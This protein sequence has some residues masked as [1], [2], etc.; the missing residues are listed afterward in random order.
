MLIQLTNRDVHTCGVL[1]ADTV[2]LCK[3]QNFNP[4]LEN[5]NQSREDANIDGFKA[6]FA[7][8]RLFNLDP[9]TLNVTS[10]HGA[11]LWLTDNACIDVKCSSTGDLI[12]DTMDK[13]GADIA[14][15]CQVT[16]DPTVV[17]IQGWVS[18][19]EFN[20]KHR[21]K[22]YGYGERLVMNRSELHPIEQLWR[23]MVT[24]KFSPVN[25]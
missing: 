23:Q 25:K 15:L 5:E 16:S 19:I 8:A 22:D 21:I 20:F 10:D 4:R 13:F 12:F 18:R 17:E 11:D 2:K 3:M 24:K 1:G 7:V 14:V 9:P 6:E